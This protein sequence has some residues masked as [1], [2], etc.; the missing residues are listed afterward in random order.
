M[1]KCML[2]LDGV[3]VDFLAGAHKFHGL[4]YS[5]EDYPYTLG[6]YQ[7][8][9]PPTSKMT[10]REFWDKLGHEFWADLSWILGGRTI[11]AMVED[12]FGKE[13]TCLLTTPTLNHGCITGKME[14][15]ECEMPDY[16]RRYLIGPVKYFCASPDTVLIDDSDHNVNAFREAGGQAILV[17]RPW[18]SAYNWATIP[19][20]QACLGII[21]RN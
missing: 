10:T 13:N 8:C 7:N 19:S 17:P 1:L 20:I 16:R 11:L 12:F 14:W 21:E 3:L 2:D 5:N 6:E 18:N 4:P 15:I 9:P